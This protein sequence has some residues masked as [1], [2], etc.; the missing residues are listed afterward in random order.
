M[1]TN[2]TKGE[3]TMTE[4]IAWTTKRQVSKKAAEQIR[5]AVA[6][7]DPSMDFVRHYAA[8]NDIH[9]W[10]VR[11]NDGSNDCNHVRERTARCIAEAE[12]ILAE[13]R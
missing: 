8:G 10:L 4:Y 7:I 6:A 12:R 9:G 1:K 13:A 3:T 5:A 11:P 2:Q